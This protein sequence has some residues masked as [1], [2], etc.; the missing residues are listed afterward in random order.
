M[1]DKDL[2]TTDYLRQGNRSVVLP[3]LH[4]LHVIHENNIILL[5]ALVVDFGLV[6]VSASHD[7]ELGVCS[8]IRYGLKLQMVVICRQSF[9]VFWAVRNK[10]AREEQTSLW[11]LGHGNTARESN[12][13]CQ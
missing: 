8:C 11:V 6:N 9:S 10:E 2:E 3:V 12:S 4:G 13:T 1:G 7:D 5:L